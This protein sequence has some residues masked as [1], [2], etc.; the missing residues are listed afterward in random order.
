MS[1]P[2]V[3]VMTFAHDSIKGHTMFDLYKM[4]ASTRTAN[5]DFNYYEGVYIQCM[6]ERAMRETLEQGMDYAFMVDSDMRLPPNTL[7]RLLA[8]NKEFVGCNVTSRTQSGMTVARNFQDECVYTEVATEKYEEVLA[9]GFGI[10]LIKL[11]RV[12]TMPEP[13]FAMPWDIKLRRYIGEDMSFCNGFRHAGGK[14]FV[15]HEL[16]REIRHIGAIELETL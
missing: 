3:A 12:R 7:D 16:S 15:D 2:T 13:L 9:L 14:I 1:K 6:R 5:I 4:L 11:D 8:A 10:V